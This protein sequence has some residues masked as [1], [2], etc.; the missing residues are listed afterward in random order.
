MPKVKTKCG[1]VYT[2][3]AYYR[4]RN[5]KSTT[6]GRKSKY[7]RENMAKARAARGSSTATVRDDPVRDTRTSAA[8]RDESLR[9]RRSHMH[10]SS[11]DP[12]LD[13]DHVN[14]IVIDISKYIWAI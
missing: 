2:Q 14:M 10:Q 11:E 4:E 12:V 3:A 7:K 1:K 6:R 5:R 9:I 8:G 13:N